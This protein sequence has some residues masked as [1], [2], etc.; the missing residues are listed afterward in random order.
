M[1]IKD[2]IN[3]LREKLN[4]HNINYYVFDNPTITDYEYDILLKEL[5]DLENKNPSLL[6]RISPTKRVEKNPIKEF[7]TI[8][9]SRP[10]LS[11][12]NAMDESELDD[13]NKQIIK[14]VNSNIEYIAEL[15]LDGLAVEL[16]YK[17]GKFVYGS[18]RG[19]GH[20]GED[21]T[22]NLKTIKGI[23]NLLTGKKN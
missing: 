7:G 16:V 23:V 22:N 20:V 15:K 13:F 2:R 12:A 1:K 9:H 8:K 11:L 10:M 18:T 21:I 3:S 6:M 14:I 17:N 5:E 19:D 4:Q